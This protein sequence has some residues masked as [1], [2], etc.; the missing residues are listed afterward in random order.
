MRQVRNRPTFGAVLSRPNFNFL[1]FGVFTFP[2]GRQGII[3]GPMR[4]LFVCFYIIII[5]IIINL[6]AQ[7]YIARILRE[8]C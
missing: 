7:K 5:I 6:L 8:N 2:V 4:F 1:F 3:F